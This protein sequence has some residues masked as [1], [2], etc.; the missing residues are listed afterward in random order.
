MT[1]DGISSELIGEVKG[2]EEDSFLVFSA[3]LVGA[4]P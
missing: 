4:G 3:E 2:L 1:R